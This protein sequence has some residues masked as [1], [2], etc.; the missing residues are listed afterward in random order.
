MNIFPVMNP[1]GA[2]RSLGNT[3]GIAWWARVDT[4]NPEGTYWFGPFLTK[5]SL[6]GKLPL[7]IDDLTTEGTEGIDHSFVRC[8]RSEPLT[9]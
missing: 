8:R 9:R 4:N 5:R 2:I 3:L 6:I 7:F 1:F